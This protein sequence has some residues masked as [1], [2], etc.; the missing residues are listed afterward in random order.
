MRGFSVKG[1]LSLVEPEGF[2]ISA[3]I[4]VDALGLILNEPLRLA[5]G[6]LHFL[7]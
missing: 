6:A 5:F 2:A 4:E 3:K 1:E 7:I